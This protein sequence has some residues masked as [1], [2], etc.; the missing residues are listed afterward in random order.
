M[1]AFLEQAHVVEKREEAYALTPNGRRMLDE[2]AEGEWSGFTAVVIGTGAYNNEIETLLTVAETAEGIATCDV[3]RARSNFPRL[4]SI[5]GWNPA[6]RVGRQLVVPLA[7]LEEILGTTS[8]HIVDET[9]DWVR[10]MEAVGRRAEAYT[11]RRERSL[12]GAEMVL[13][14]SRDSGDRFGYDVEIVAPPGRFIEVKGSRA[15]RV[16][17]MLTRNE[18][19]AA[20]RLA[21]RHELQFWGEISLQRRPQDEYELLVAKGYPHVF[22]Q[23]PGIIRDTDAWSLQCAV[24][25]VAKHDT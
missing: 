5:L 1:L 18:L 21:D 14:V 12:H 23:V 3:S 17:F 22:H 20:E 7:V 19:H 8:I 6:Y 9:P 4:G 2:L 13:Y 15:A 16:S 25:Q 10:D 11:L 24:W